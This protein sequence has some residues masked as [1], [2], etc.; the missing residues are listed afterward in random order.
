MNSLHTIERKIN[1]EASE[2]SNASLGTELNVKSTE[3]TDS[4]VL[5]GK[6]EL[7]T[8]KKLYASSK[9]VVESHFS[10]KRPIGYI[11]IKDNKNNCIQSSKMGK[12]IQAKCEGD[13]V[14]WRFIR[15]NNNYIIE[16]RNNHVL[17]NYAGDKKDN[18]S[19]FS[20]VRNNKIN[21]FWKIIP[22]KG[23]NFSIKSV[24]SGKCIE[25]AEKG[26]GYIQRKCSPNERQNFTNSSSS[27]RPYKFKVNSGYVNI[28]GKGKLCLHADFKKSI[29]QGPCNSADSALW[30]FNEVEGN[31]YV[32]QS[33]NSQVLTVAQGGKKNGDL[34]LG[35]DRHDSSFQKWY[36][37][38]LGNSE[39][40]L[41]SFHSEKC[42]DNTG[43]VSNGVKYQQWSCSKGNK[44]QIFK[45]VNPS[46]STSTNK[47][48][49][50]IKNSSTS[51]SSSKSIRDSVAISTL[52]RS[53]KKN[54]SFVQKKVLP[55]KGWGMIK[56]MGNLC[57]QSSKNNRI[58]Q[59]KCDSKNNSLWRFVRDG[60]RGHYFVQNKNGNILEV[61]ASQ[62]NDKAHIYAS[63]RLNASNQ[64][65]KFLYIG[66][67]YWELENRNSKK[68]ID[69]T[70]DAK[71]GNGYHQMNCFDYNFNQL[72]T[73]IDKNGKN[74]YS[75]KSKNS[76]K[77]INRT[78]KK[79][80][81]NKSL[82][83]KNKQ[84]NRSFRTSKRNTKNRNISKRRQ[85]DL[86][87]NSNTS[88]KT[89]KSTKQLPV[90]NNRN[91]TGAKTLQNGSKNGSGSKK[92]NITQRKGATKSKV[93]ISSKTTKTNRNSRNVASR[94]NRT[95]RRSRNA[96]SK[97]RRNRRGSRKAK[98]RK[99]NIAR[100]KALR[101]TKNAENKV[102]TNK[103]VTRA[104]VAKN[105]KVTGTKPPTNTKVTRTKVPTNTKVTGSKAS[106]N[107]NVTGTN[108][109][110]KNSVA[111]TNRSNR[112]LRNG[113]SRNKRS[114][115]RSR[116]SARSNRITRRSRNAARSNRTTRRS[117]N[118]R[119]ARRSRRPRRSRGSRRPRRSR[120]AVS[121]V[122]GTIRRSGTAPLR[123]SAGR[124]LASRNTKVTGTAGRS[125]R[126]TGNSTRT[127]RKTTTRD[128]GKATTNNLKGTSRNTNTGG[129][130]VKTT[131]NT[132][133]N[134][135][136]GS[137]NTFTT[138]TKIVTKRVNATKTKV[139]LGGKYKFNKISGEEFCS[140]N[141]EAN[142]KNTSNP[143]C[144][145]IK[146]D[147]D[148][149]RADYT[150]LCK[151][152]CKTNNS[153]TCSYIN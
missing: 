88:S 129:K 150:Q 116:N 147:G 135:V 55:P 112:S 130:Q 30:K 107:T 80:S 115:R 67:G 54:S 146:V 11:M 59:G 64:K 89:T 6:S 40:S 43:I 48:N 21:Q 98:S 102:P 1:S 79:N 4:E 22:G 15:F 136:S 149:L 41:K 114:V 10:W 23:A 42:I 3:L 61:Y 122:R 111:G 66:D 44:D 82:V 119:T 36:Y 105:T 145:L 141:C 47:K 35:W 19:I 133:R 28:R 25:R 151:T 57:I 31:A 110:R 96:T 99:N 68:C 142:F 92:K 63:K 97:N 38:N 95:K 37:I 128:E 83:K 137:T 125:T 108:V 104:K 26:N 118:A 91:T 39:F 16:S 74:Y 84:S 81:R 13:L 78:N 29:V 148:R 124:T 7:S 58:L 72:F 152:M 144:K 24:N 138:K 8:I 69:M 27:L 45:N 106:T 94:S 75:K 117:R 5:K 71:I 120:T 139:Y 113:A 12:V 103:K 20:W 70:G 126:T 153:K 65:W 9:T 123:N 85:G 62:K 101:N 52:K 143:Q 134:G 132:N 56:G 49:S 60:K 18:T 2:N 90:K 73:F 33:K 140:N 53:L 127:L 131:S 32:I 46:I 14:Q 34:I 51:S 17:D 77:R 100:N 76:R 121:R 87:K 93:G 109:T 86:S 50:R